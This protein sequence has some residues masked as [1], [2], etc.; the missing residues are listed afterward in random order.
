MPSVL[1]R[2]ILLILGLISSLLLHSQTAD[3]LSKNLTERDSS[4]KKISQRLQ[5]ETLSSVLLDSLTKLS[6]IHI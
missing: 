5:R 4:A 2:S 6:L 1:I 3:P